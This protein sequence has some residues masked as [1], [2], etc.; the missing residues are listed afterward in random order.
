MKGFFTSFLTAS[1]VLAI[2]PSAMAVTI[3]FND[4]VPGSPSIYLGAG[5]VDAIP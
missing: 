2:M 4:T 1:T 5:G 3:D